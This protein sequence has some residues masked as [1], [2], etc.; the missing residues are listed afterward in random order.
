MI[1]DHQFFQLFSK[2]TWV[3]N[4]FSCPVPILSG[5]PVSYHLCVA[6]T[7]DPI[8]YSY[9]QHIGRYHA[10]PY[11]WFGPVGR[12]T[13]IHYLL[14][15]NGVLYR[16]WGWWLPLKQVINTKMVM[17]SFWWPNTGPDVRPSADSALTTQI[18][19][20]KLYF[21]LKILYAF[22]MIRHGPFQLVTQYNLGKIQFI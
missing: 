10:L 5:S 1:F 11:Q 13:E 14:T 3:G 18:L 6:T 2:C 16:L 22:L 20:S 8:T 17:S 7:N 15:G 12:S 19:F 21:V 9:Y 4:I